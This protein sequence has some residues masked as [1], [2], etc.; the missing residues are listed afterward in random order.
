MELTPPP[1]ATPPPAEGRRPL[2]R[3]PAMRATLAMLAALAVHLAAA[4]ELPAGWKKDG[5]AARQ[6]R[7]GVDR[8][9][10][11]NGGGA[12]AYLQSWTAVPPN[13]GSVTQTID[14]ALYHGK[15]VRLTGWL[16]TEEVDHDEGWAGLWVRTDGRAGRLSYANTHEE[17]VR[18]TA[19][20]TRVNVVV[21]VDR[22]AEVISFGFMLMGS[23]KVWADDLAFEE[24]GRD[25]P[26]TPFE[27]PRE[28][29]KEPV[30]LS[31]DG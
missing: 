19:G 17:P 27:G 11:R 12:S 25:V 30:N 2:R 22:R 10:S 14:A 7:A 20:W 16:R 15:R 6:Y 18:E 13:S 23:G 9:V 5:R 29:P 24:V 3:R 1:Q 31:F 28:L 26:V 4:A 8:G 21:D